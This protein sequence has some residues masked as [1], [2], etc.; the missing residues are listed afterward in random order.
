MMEIELEQLITVS[1]RMNC[2][3]PVAVYCRSTCQAHDRGHSHL[4]QI[5]VNERKQTKSTTKKW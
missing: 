1:W 5:N 3:P 4:K 2:T